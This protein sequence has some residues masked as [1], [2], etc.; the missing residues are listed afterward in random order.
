[1]ASTGDCARLHIPGAFYDVIL[2]C[3]ARQDIFFTRE[4]RSGFDGLLA[5][6]VRR[7]TEDSLCR[8]VRVRAIY[9]Q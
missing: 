5:E 6:S 7:A 3:N 9:S 2:R 1:M 4:D 8:S